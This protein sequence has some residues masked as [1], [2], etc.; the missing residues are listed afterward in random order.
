[1]NE[2]R[3]PPATRRRRA[4]DLVIGGYTFDGVCR[5]G[6]KI[7]ILLLCAGKKATQVRLVPDLEIPCAH[8]RVAVAF[9]HVLDEGANEIGPFGHV[10]G[11]SP[12]AAPPENGFGTAC[13]R[14]WHEAQF[15]KRPH[16]DA[17]EKIVK[18][19]NV[20]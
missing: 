11:G 17:V 16:A 4:A 19:V 8:L 14:R 20:L 15:Y 7:E 12:I 5:C 3:H 10:S 2:L 13:Q 18:L 1:M 6:V 9:L